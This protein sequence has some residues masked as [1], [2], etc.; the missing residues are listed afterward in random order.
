MACPTH[1]WAEAAHI[2]PHP[3][4]SP[5][6]SSLFPLLVSHLPPS[7]RN[8]P[9]GTEA[10]RERMRLLPGVFPAMKPSARPLGIS[11]RPACDWK[12]TANKCPL[13]M[14]AASRRDIRPPRRR[15]IN[16][17][18]P[19]G[20][21]ATDQVVFVGFLSGLRWLFI[22]TANGKDSPDWE[23]FRS[24]PAFEP[25]PSAHKNTS[26]WRSAGIQRKMMTFSN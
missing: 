26:A 4:S 24:V 15:A 3:H 14:D 13:R 11:A 12:H 1:G 25:P 21:R 22:D 5:R 2:H 10:A 9:N 8:A 17:P 7:P 19:N 23:L 6:L 20:L 16:I 18:G